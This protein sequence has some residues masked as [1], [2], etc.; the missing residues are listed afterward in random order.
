MMARN[1][2]RK[3]TRAGLRREAGVALGFLAPSLVG[4]GVLVLIPTLD[5]LRRSFFTA[6]GNA[7]VGLSNYRTVLGNP[8]FRLAAGNT[9][10]FI[11]LCIPLLLALSLGAALLL[12]RLRRFQ[13]LLKTTYLL[14]L[15]IPVSSVVLVIQAV[16]HKNGLVS[17][18]LGSPTDWLATPWAFWVLVL[19][20]IWKNLGY[21]VVLWLAGLCAI[22][23]SLYEAARVDGATEGQCFRF[24]T[25]P[26]LSPTLYMSAV[27]ALINSFKVFREAYLVAGSYPH[28]SI[29]MLQH[30]LSNWF[31]DLEMQKISAAA[32]L[33][34]FAVLLFAALLQWRQLRKGADR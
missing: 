13:S 29:Y 33:L 19:C 23:A 30:V 26:M 22:P 18:L 7:F 3:R 32:V 31:V 24:I 25:L 11:L 20:Y 5:V 6:M 2:T 14:P 34:L 17:A 8:S 1:Q 28:D 10:R 9:L 12:S 4:V 21:H 16:F 27:L 15:C